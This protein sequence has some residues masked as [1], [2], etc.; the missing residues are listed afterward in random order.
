M[1]EIDC[2]KPATHREGMSALNLRRGTGIRRR[3][4]WNHIKTR[5][6]SPEYPINVTPGNALTIVVWSGIPRLIVESGHVTIDFRSSWGNSL[7]VRPAASA[8]V[9]T[10]GHSKVTIDN[11]GSLHVDAPE[12][13]RVRVYGPGQVTGGEFPKSIFG[14][15]IDAVRGRDG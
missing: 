3:V 8:H 12:E 13:N 1:T 14:T 11:E 10:D 4:D 5:D 6:V 9:L 15:V 7:K 2:R